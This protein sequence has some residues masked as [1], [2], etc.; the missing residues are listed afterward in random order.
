MLDKRYVFPFILK[1]KAFIFFILK[2]M[3]F[4]LYFVKYVFPFIW[5]LYLVEHQESQLCRDI[6][7]GLMRHLNLQGLHYRGAIP[8]LDFR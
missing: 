4:L 8:H 2:N 7:A 1:G 5:V 6:L 3:Y